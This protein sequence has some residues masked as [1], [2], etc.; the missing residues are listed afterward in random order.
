MSRDPIEELWP[1]LHWRDAADPV[2]PNTYAFVAS[3]P[4][5]VVDPDGRLLI[6][7]PQVRVIP[8]CL[9]FPPPLIPKDVASDIAQAVSDTYHQAEN[10]VLI[11]G[12]VVVATAIDTAT[13]IICRI[14]GRCK[15]RP[16]RKDP[17]KDD[18]DKCLLSAIGDH[19]PESYQGRCWECYLACQGRS[20]M[21]GGWGG[22]M[23]GL[24]CAYWNYRSM[25]SP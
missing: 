22:T 4:L 3:N 17:C 1:G 7:L 20:R 2:E 24:D 8:P 18:Y 6:T 21:G 19:Y 25:G 14:K 5:N 15:P 13:D 23:N 16:P 11:A 9:P 10:A 12:V